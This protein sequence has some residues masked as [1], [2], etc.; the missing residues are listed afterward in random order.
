V[1]ALQLIEQFP[2]LQGPTPRFFEVP[3]DVQAPGLVVVAAG[4]WQ[5]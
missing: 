4:D 5:P 1:A 3:A 2:Q